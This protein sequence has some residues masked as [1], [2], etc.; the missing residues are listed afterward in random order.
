ML[1]KVSHYKPIENKISL[2]IRDETNK[3]YAIMIDQIFDT[4]DIVTKPLSQFIPK[5]S[6]LHGTT[7]LGDGTVTAVIDIVELLNNIS[8]RSANDLHKNDFINTQ[9]LNYSAL[10]VEDA[11]STRKSLAQFMQ[12]LGFNVSTAKDGVEAVDMIRRQV[13]S[14]VLTDLE[15]PRMNG[16][17]LIDHL[18]ANTETALIPIIMITSKA[19][20]KHRKEAQRLGVNAYITKPYNEDELLTLINSFKIAS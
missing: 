19:T 7:I 1:E 17:E 15:M 18:R 16:L 11:I 12:D 4:R 3:K 20:G 14:I 13:P 5:I 2:I 6:G 9:Q 10:I 8:S